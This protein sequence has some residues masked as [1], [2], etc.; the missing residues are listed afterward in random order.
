MMPIGP[1][2]TEHRLIERMVAQLKDELSRIQAIHEVNPRFI[3]VATDFFRVYADIC[4]HGK[5][6][7]IL[8]SELSEKPLSPEHRAMMEE[9]IHEHVFARSI[10]KELIEYNSRY[11]RGS[12]EV[13]PNIVHTLD[14]IISFYPTH[15]EKEDKHFFLPSMEYFSQTELDNMLKAFNEFDRKLI[16]Q[17]YKEKV[18]Q[19]EQ[20]SGQKR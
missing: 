5:E 12:M 17:L 3:E 9:L 20:S 4:H 7:H 18:L 6:E 10:V 8:F 13:L 11:E 1:L 2:M 16:H 15:I 19:L 14:L